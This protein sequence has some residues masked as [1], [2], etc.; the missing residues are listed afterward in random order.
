MSNTRC[1]RI[2]RGRSRNTSWFN[3]LRQIDGSAL[4]SSNI[5]NLIS[6][7]GQSLSLGSVGGSGTP[8]VVSTDSYSNALMADPGGTRPRID[9]SRI[10]VDSENVFADR[11]ASLTT[12]AESVNSNFGE[13]YNLGIASRNSEIKTLH[14]GIGRGAQTISNLSLGSFYFT[15]LMI[16]LNR[17]KKRVDESGEEFAWPIHWWAQG[18]A[19]TVAQTDYATYK[20][21]LLQYYNDLVDFGNAQLN[22]TYSPSFVTYQVGNPYVSSGVS[23]YGP[24]DALLDFGLEQSF[25][26]CV[27]PQYYLDY[28]DTAH[29]TS[30]NYRIFGEQ[31][32]K[33]INRIL[34]GDDWKPL[35]WTNVSRTGTTIT[36][37]Y[38]VPSGSL[39]IDTTIVSDPG[40]YGFEYSG[41]NITNVSIAS[42][43]T[44]EITIDAS[45]GGTLD[46]ARTATNTNNIGRTFGPR[47]NIRDT[48][49]ATAIHDGSNLYNWACHQSEVVA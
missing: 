19:D 21:S 44:I 13:T 16:A 36:I 32:G 3:R 23:N 39:A 20:S 40:D 30:L 35:Y 7:S 28:E 9:D 5:R 12:L 38:N 4:V 10:T 42:A 31:M 6:H 29:L 48:D 2:R 25:A 33:V 18:E 8:S 45:A 47:G 1:R 43:N 14:T 26:F 46:Y 17:S 37:T 11:F 24:Q 49:T 34:D 22:G 27:G 15:D 41:A